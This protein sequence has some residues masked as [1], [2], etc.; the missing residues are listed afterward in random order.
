MGLEREALITIERGLV[1]VAVPRIADLFG[2]DLR[3]CYRAL[4]TIPS[5]CT[6]PSEMSEPNILEAPNLR[7]AQGQLIVEVSGKDTGR[8]EIVGRREPRHAR[9]LVSQRPVL[10]V[11]VGISAEHDEYE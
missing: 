3:E 2:R 1:C 8:D 6:E 9:S 11:S 4:L 10:E 7:E 5:V